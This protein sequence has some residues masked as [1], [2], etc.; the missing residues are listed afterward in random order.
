MQASQPRGRCRRKRKV[1]KWPTDQIVVRE[2]TED[3]MPTEEKAMTRMRKLAGL[4]ARQRLSLVMPSFDVLTDD[5]KKQL[6]DECV[7]PSLHFEVNLRP[8]ALKMMM[9]IVKHSWR[10]YKSELVRLFVRPGLNARE[11]HPFIPLQEWEAFVALHNTDEAKKKSERFRKLRER[12]KHNHCLGTTGYAG[13]AK[14]WEKQDRD[15][16]TNGISNP[17]H[18]YPEGRPRSY[19]RA[20]SKLVMSEGSAKIQWVSKSTERVSQQV[21]EKQ[22]ELESS[23]LTYTLVRDKDVLTQVLGP[24]QTRHIRGFS[25]YSGWKYWPN[26]SSMYRKRK[27]SDVDV[28]VDAIKDELREELTKDIIAMLCEQ[29]VN[30]VLPSNTLPSVGGMKSS[31]ALA[32]DAVYNNVQLDR[33]GGISYPNPVDLVGNATSCTLVSNQVE[34]GKGKVF[35]MQTELYSV[36]VQDGYVVVLVDFVH[37]EH[38]SFVLTPP[39]LLR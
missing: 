24:E 14:K 29:G 26:C 9:R 31:C 34:V 28:D 22:I 16:A 38:E 11:K 3:G 23:R 33:P 19:L 12:N 20:R 4:I 17:W 15:L 7:E 2:L 6:F 32:S 25:S 10:T 8:T 5:D 39:Q 21:I 27:R 13:A 37:P 1:A 18:R 36:P 30:L 35:P